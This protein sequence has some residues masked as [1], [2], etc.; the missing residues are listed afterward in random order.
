MNRLLP[1]KHLPAWLALAG[2]IWGT[3]SLQAGDSPSAPVA[4][5]VKDAICQSTN[6][7]SKE[8][9]NPGSRAVALK[10]YLAEQEKLATTHSKTNLAKDCDKPPSRADL[11]KKAASEKK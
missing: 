10:A 11:L 3:V 8:C 9:H 1:V 7:V 4:S 2:G 5:P 6:G